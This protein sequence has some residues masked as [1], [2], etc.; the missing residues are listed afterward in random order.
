MN[1]DSGVNRDIVGIPG[2]PELIKTHNKHVRF[3]QAHT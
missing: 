2:I 1:T 3:I